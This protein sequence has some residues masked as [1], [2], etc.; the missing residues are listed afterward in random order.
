MYGVPLIDDDFTYYEGRS[1]TTSVGHRKVF[2]IHHEGYYE[3]ETWET[4]MIDIIEMWPPTW[5]DIFRYRDYEE[6]N[7]D[8]LELT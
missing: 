6:E 1:W 5:E 7:F 3:A 4:V 2:E 8:S